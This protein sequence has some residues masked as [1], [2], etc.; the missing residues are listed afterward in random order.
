MSDNKPNSSYAEK[1][2][3]KRDWGLITASVLTAIFLILGFVGSAATNLL[4]PF[5]FLFG[6]SMFASFLYLIVR[7]AISHSREK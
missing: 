5:G 4:A 2:S 7:L 1:E 3:P 6:I